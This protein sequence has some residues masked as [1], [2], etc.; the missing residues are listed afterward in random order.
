VSGTVLECD[1]KCE[2]VSHGGLQQTMLEMLKFV[3]IEETSAR[4]L[5]SQV[6]KG[7]VVHSHTAVIGF[8]LCASFFS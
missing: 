4:I 3:S 7:T 5:I 8:V 2:G 1:M 6:K